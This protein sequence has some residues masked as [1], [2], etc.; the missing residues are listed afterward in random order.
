MPAF[1][2]RRFTGT[3]RGGGRRIPL[4]PLTPSTTHARASRLAWRAGSDDDGL[5]NALKLIDPLFEFGDPLLALNQRTRRIRDLIDL[6]HQS[7]RGRSWVA[8][9]KLLQKDTHDTD[10]LSKALSLQFFPD[11]V[12]KCGFDL[13]RVCIR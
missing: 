6:G 4:W 3:S 13:V 12:S 11:P 2:T 1:M 7:R 5:L 8:Y 10:C 9:R